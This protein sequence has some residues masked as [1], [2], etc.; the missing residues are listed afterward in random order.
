MPHVRHHSTR[1]SDT[2]RWDLQR[3]TQNMQ[4]VDDEKAML[5]EEVA[6][7]QVMLMQVRII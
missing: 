4:N 7:L 3:V 2:T 6:R 5:R 1:L